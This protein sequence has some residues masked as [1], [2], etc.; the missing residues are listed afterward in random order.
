MA[1]AK[2][3]YD[4]TTSAEASRN[5]GLDR[6]A[7][8][9]LAQNL[10]ERHPYYEM[11]VKTW[12]MFMDFYEATNL[13]QYIDKHTRETGEHYEARKRR[14]VFR[15]YVKSIIELY[16]HY[17]F[18]KEIV[19]SA[20][21]RTSR[22]EESD[23]D[24]V[25]TVSE[26]VGGEQV[27]PSEAGI[28]GNGNGHDPLSEL[29]GATSSN[30][31]QSGVDREW[32]QLFLNDC[33]RAGTSLQN[34]MKRSASM[35]NLFGKVYLLVDNPRVE[36]DPD[37]E[38]ERRDM[39]IRPYVTMYTPL[40]VTNWELDENGK[41]LW[42]RTRETATGLLKAF[43]ARSDAMK[44]M[45]ADK[46]GITSPRAPRFAVSVSRP[47]TFYRTWTKEEW[48]IHQVQDGLAY[49]IASGPNE[50]GEVPM[51]NCYSKKGARYPFGGLSLIEEIAN[52]QKMILN[53][54]SLITEGIFLQ[55]LSILV[56]GRGG[57]DTEEII[58]SEKNVLEV[59]AGS[60]PPFYLTPSQA[61]LQYMESRLQ[62]LTQEIYR[63]SK[64]G[65]AY[66]MEPKPMAATTASFEFNMT[67]RAL[68]ERA[69]NLELAEF[70]VHEFW[71]KWM[72][73]VFRGYIEYPDDFSVE[74]FLEDLQVLS[75]AQGAIR[76]ET[77]RRELEKK[78]SKKILATHD[79]GIITKVKREIE[80]TPSRI[81]GATGPI[82]YD[83]ITQE[84]NMPGSGN[85]VGELADVLREKGIELPPPAPVTGAQQAE[86]QQVAAQ[87]QQIAGEQQQDA[88]AVSTA[89]QL[90]EQNQPQPPP[91]K[92]A[93]KKPSGAKA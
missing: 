64:F 14:Y 90:Q 75:S 46:F 51:V 11:R 76:S 88:A 33:D 86:Q 47:P 21:R 17:I 34:F 43:E 44:R 19:R 89:G 78:I 30:V 59:A 55:C 70:Q 58:I 35:A 22:E 57:T 93:A 13:E 53:I 66:G 39:Q 67:N 71:Y 49:E 27:R 62:V 37:N 45:L 72:N 4:A 1:L 28:N 60:F 38:Q 69:E 84:V 29:T 36:R 50:L 83:D 18:S 61:P 87:Q 8:A 92:P 26:T 82:Y 5:A 42:V 80:F 77:F 3:F 54:D 2:E 81:M 91:K 7:S 20:E 10:E 6:R 15:P 73:G 40:D 12:Q 65:G 9:L 74:S 63:L 41:F 48:T 32:E 24:D 56:T 79:E 25:E 31:G 68:A 52:I 23:T 85:V 16:E